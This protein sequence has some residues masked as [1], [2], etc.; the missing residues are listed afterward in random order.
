MKT[1]GV[2]ALLSWY[3]QV[4]REGLPVPFAQSVLSERVSASRRLTLD[5]RLGEGAR[6]FK[7]I[8]AVLSPLPQT[9][10]E[11]LFAKAPEDPRL[12]SAFYK[13]RARLLIKLR[14]AFLEAGLLTNDER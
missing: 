12:R 4:G 6:L 8:E 10:R 1:K 9:E 11:L 3:R 7:R 2:E 13:R 5:L 14:L